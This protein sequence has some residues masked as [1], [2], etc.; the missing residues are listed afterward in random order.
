MIFSSIENVKAKM[1][2]IPWRRLKSAKSYV[3]ETNVR[4]AF[5]KGIFM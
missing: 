3:E 2:E 4:G 1:N 5:D